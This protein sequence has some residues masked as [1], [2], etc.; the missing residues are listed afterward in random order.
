M[1]GASHTFAT[2]YDGTDLAVGRVD[3]ATISW[4][5]ETTVFY[6]FGARKGRNFSLAQTLAMACHSGKRVVA[7]G[8]I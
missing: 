1:P 6:L 5:S 8:P 7:L 2:F 4:L 3:P